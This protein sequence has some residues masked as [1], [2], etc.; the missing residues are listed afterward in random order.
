MPAWHQARSLQGRRHPCLV[1]EPPHACGQCRALGDSAA[2]LGALAR[3]WGPCRALGGS[4]APLGV[5]TRR[6]GHWHAPG[7]VPRRWGQWHAPGAVGALGAAP[8]TW[9]KRTW[10]PLGIVGDLGGSAHG[11]PW[12]QCCGVAALP[13][14]LPWK[15]SSRPLGPL[16]RP[17]HAL[18]PGWP[19]LTARWPRLTARWPRLTARWPRLTARR[20]CREAVRV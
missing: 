8:R 12:G 13:G 7:T 14:D 18:W 4:A 19:R 3:P 9:G 17:P 1:P 15:G 6:W 10:E 20:C 11:S 2:P 16:L 5:V